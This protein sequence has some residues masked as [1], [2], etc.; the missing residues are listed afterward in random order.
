MIRLPMIAPLVA[1]LLLAALA[2]EADAGAKRSRPVRTG[3]TT[4]WNTAGDVIDCV[5]T[6]HDGELR[7]GEPRAYLDLGDGTIRDQRT[8]LMWEKLSDDG[9][10]HDKDTTYTW[11]NAVAVKIATLN[12]PPCFAGF[13]DWRLPNSFELYSLVNLGS[14]NPAVSPA[15]NT[16]CAASCTVLACSCTVPANYWSSS[17]YA[18]N[19]SFAWGVNFS[20]GF[21]PAD[22]KNSSNRVRAVRGGS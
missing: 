5:G 21:T 19:P 7:R 13:C 18:L 8:A 20:D 2:Q 3:Q 14:V 1:G 15:F 17:S 6:G 11:A 12:T 4:C 16:G 9:S 22:F 10:I